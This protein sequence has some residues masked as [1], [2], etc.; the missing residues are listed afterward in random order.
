MNR[1]N[2]IYNK[3][4]DQFVFDLMI[5]HPMKTFMKTF[6]FMSFNL[7]FTALIGLGGLTTIPYC[8]KMIKQET[9]K[10]KIFYILTFIQILLQTTFPLM[11]AGLVIL[12]MMHVL[13]FDAEPFKNCTL[14]GFQVHWQRTEIDPRFFRKTVR[15]KFSDILQNRFVSKFKRNGYL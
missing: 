5:G 13:F 3:G 10:T 6:G 9:T 15:N 7:I 14:V 11:R 2:R 4:F 12:S 8:F 1:S